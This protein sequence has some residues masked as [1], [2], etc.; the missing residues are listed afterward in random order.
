MPVVLLA[1]VQVAGRPCSNFV[2][3]LAYPQGL[4]TNVA[5]I[6]LDMMALTR[7]QCSSGTVE[8]LFS[9]LAI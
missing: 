7:V 2:V 3:L 6:V 9:V 8:A 4:S 5:P 1:L